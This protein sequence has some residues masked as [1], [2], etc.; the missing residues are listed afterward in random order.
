MSTTDLDEFTAKLRTEFLDEARFLLEQCEEALLSLEQAPDKAKEL[1]EIFRVAHTVK[2]SGG[3]VGF[4]DLV[5]FAH[6]FEDCLSVLRNA[7]QLVTS[8]VVSLLLRNV[9]AL[10]ARVLSYQLGSDAPWDPRELREET[11]GVT[12]ALSG[13]EPEART[14]PGFGFFDDPA[15]HEGL[16][17]RSTPVT[18]P[19]IDADAACAGPAAACPEPAPSPEATPKDATPK[20]VTPKDVTS[21]EAFSPKEAGATAA[22]AGKP[23]GGSIKVDAER[24]DGVLDVVGELVVVKSQLL[25]RLGDYQ[26]DV[27]LQS[28]ASLLDG[29]VRDLQGRALSI[30]MMPLKPLFLK[31]QRLVRDLSLRFG[32]KVELHMIGEETE[33]DRTTVEQLADPLMHM[34]RNAIDHGIEPL[35]TRLRVGKRE[36]GSVTLEARQAGGRVVIEVRDDGAGIPRDRVLKKAVDRGIVTKDQAASMS[37]KDVFNLIFAPGFST[38][39]VVS[40]VSGRGVGM[41]V[42]RTNVERMK[43]TV[44]LAS[45]PGLGSTFTLSLPLT[46]SIADG[47]MVEIS[48]QPFVIPMDAVR[49]LVDAKSVQRA[50]NASRHQGVVTIRDRVLPHIDLARTLTPE[51]ERATGAP[52]MLVVTEVLGRTVAL[53][54]EAVVGQMQ[55]V[56]KPLGTLLGRPPGVSGAAVLGDGRVALVLD[57]HGIVEEALTASRSDADRAASA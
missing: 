1:A 22:A 14:S 21:K 8:D 30:R 42:V 37:D 47:I 33:I 39:E 44:D 32:K 52:G 13:K 23:S 49:E 6:V 53:G 57:V 46:A 48:G 36:V 51:H 10:K 15:A 25:N 19:S 5:E 7:P 2:G 16:P 12:R 9:D 29:I 38:A 41:D 31:L 43:G 35:E 50:A 11:A 45:Q 26:N 54:V 18:A 17:S 20:D 4:K 34:M 55:C 24:I 40:D 56:L 28:I 27:A 3:A